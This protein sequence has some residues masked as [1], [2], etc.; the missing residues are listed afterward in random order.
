[1]IKTLRIEVGARVQVTESAR[2]C[3]RRTGIVRGKAPFRK[4]VVDIAGE[5]NGAWVFGSLEIQRY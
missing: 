5:P 4:Y 1:V 3:Y 2:H